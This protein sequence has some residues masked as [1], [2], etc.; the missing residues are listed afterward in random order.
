LFFANASYIKGRVQEALRG[1][2]TP[3]LVVDAER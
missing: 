2:P 3:A 1:A